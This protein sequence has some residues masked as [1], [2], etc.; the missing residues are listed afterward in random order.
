MADGSVAFGDYFI[1]I[2]TQMNGVN[3]GADGLTCQSARV[4]KLLQIAIVK[5]ADAAAPIPRLITKRTAD[6]PQHSVLVPP[7][8]EISQVKIGDF[9]FAR[10]LATLKDKH[11]KVVILV[12]ADDDNDIIIRGV[13][14]NDQDFADLLECI[15]TFKYAS[16]EREDKPPKQDASSP[17]EVVVPIAGSALPAPLV[18]VP[19]LRINIDRYE[20]VAFGPT[21]CPVIVVGKTVWN[22][23]TWKSQSVLQ[24]TIET[25]TVSA[26]SNDGKYFAAGMKSCN[27]ENTPVAI[28][29]TQTGTRRFEVPGVAKRLRRCGPVFG[30]I[31]T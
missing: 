8:T 25:S 4:A 2:P 16:P 22:V 1:R 27:P 13:A 20:D 31:N 7:E 11:L 19:N 9:S 12:A 29:S 3:A 28:W 17:R 18:A 10:G 26:L 21:G 14:E 24:G 5:R 6:D 15:S 30:G 23:Q